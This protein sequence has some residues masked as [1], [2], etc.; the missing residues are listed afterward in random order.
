MTKDDL[1]VSDVRVVMT[2]PICGEAQLIHDT[3]DIPDSY[4]GEQTVLRG[5]EGDFCPACGEVI[6]DRDNSMKVSGLLR[7]ERH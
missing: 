3:R 4:Q 5:I 7:T 2:C 1:H 6:L